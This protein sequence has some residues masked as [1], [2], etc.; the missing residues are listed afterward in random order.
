PSCLASTSHPT[1]RRGIRRPRSSSAEMKRTGTRV[2]AVPLPGAVPAAFARVNAAKWTEAARSAREGGHRLVALWG[3]D[4]RARQ[5]GFAVLAAY[6]L[7]S[8]LLV[9]DLA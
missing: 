3:C 8:G 1:S 2:E 5:G 9:V 7:Q 4:R 6:A